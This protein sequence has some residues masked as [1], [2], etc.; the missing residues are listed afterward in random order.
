[1]YIDCKSFLLQ[2]IYK[3]L[4]CMELGTMTHVERV[5]ETRKQKLEKVV[6]EEEEEEEYYPVKQKPSI[7]P[8]TL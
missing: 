6:E 1:M 7:H 5:G 2:G 3:H 4:R 8:S